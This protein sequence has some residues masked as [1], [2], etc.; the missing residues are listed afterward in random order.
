MDPSHNFGYMLA[1]SKMLLSF[2]PFNTEYIRRLSSSEIIVTT[3]FHMA[4]V[5]S[6]LAHVPMVKMKAS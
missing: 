3:V 2:K 6:R 5:A 1:N 4:K